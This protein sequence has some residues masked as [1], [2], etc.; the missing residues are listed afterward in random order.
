MK[1]KRRPVLIIAQADNGDYNALPMSSVKNR[2]N[3]DPDYDIELD[4]I[5]YPNLGLANVSY[6]RVHKQFTTNCN[7]LL[8]KVDLKSEY[9]DLFVKIM[10]KLK[11]Y[12]LKIINEAFK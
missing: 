5:D 9:P 4:P 7:S 12:N 10:N 8:F 3:I 11:E 1:T 2:S 6:V